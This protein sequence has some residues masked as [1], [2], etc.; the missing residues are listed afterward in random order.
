MQLFKKIFYH[1]TSSSN[2]KKIISSGYLASGSFI[3]EN[4]SIAKS[5][6]RQKDK[7]SDIIILQF[8]LLPTEFEKSYK[9]KFQNKVKS[10]QYV[11]EINLPTSRIYA[12]K[13]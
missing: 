9:S 11:L 8:A 4:K 12:Y 6:A 7:S 1:G 13:Q 2:Y 10:N 3:S 5:Y